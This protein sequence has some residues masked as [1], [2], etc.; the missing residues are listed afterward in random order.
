MENLD[1]QFGHQQSFISISTLGIDNIPPGH[2][3][4]LLRRVGV[5]YAR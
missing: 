2:G 5:I 3:Q 1:P 4:T